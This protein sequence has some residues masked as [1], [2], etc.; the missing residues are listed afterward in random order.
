MVVYAPSA[1][2][3]IF[4]VRTYTVS[5]HSFNQPRDDDDNDDGERKEQKK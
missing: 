3:A 1:S 2:K 5:L 4:R